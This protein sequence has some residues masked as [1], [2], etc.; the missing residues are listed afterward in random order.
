MLRKLMFLAFI[1]SVQIGIAQKKKA[2]KKAT[3]INQAIYV[4]EVPPLANRTLIQETFRKVEDINPRRTDANKIV[5]GKGY[6]KGQD[7]LLEKQQKRNQILHSGRTPDL[8]FEANSSL[9]AP[10]DPTGAIGPNHYVSAKNSA[11]AIHD[12][13][14]NVMVPSTSL[15]N[16]F[17]GESLGDPI[18]FYDNFADRFVITQFSDSPNGFLVAVC[19]GSDPVN[20]GWY[21]YRFETG[22]FPDY[23]KFSV[24][25]DGYYVTAN[26]DQ[27]SLTEEEVVFVIE[28]E[29]LLSGIADA[30]IVGFPL[31]GATVG[32]FYSPAGFNAIGASLPPEGDARILYFQDDAWETVDEDALKL[33]S[34]NVNW[35]NPSES[36]IE[37]AE[38]LTVSSGA[39]QAFDSTFDGG[40]F[41]NLPQPG[42]DGQDIDV[43]QGAVMYA[44]NYRRFCDYNAVVL[45]FAV[46]IDDRDSSDNISGIRWYELR[47]TSDGAPWT[48]Y[49]EGTYTS[50]NGKS[51]WCA[52]M[53]LDSYGNIGM[54]YTTMGTITNN[55]LEDSFASIRYTGRLTGDPLGVMTI[56]EQ[57]IAIGTGINQ[58]SRN[59][60]GDYA[61][62]TVDP[63]DDQ[64]FWHIAE[65]FE[66]TGN[67]ARNV[68]GAFKIANEIPNDVGVVSID[69]LSNQTYTTT[70]VITVTV[71]NFGTQAQSNI[72]VAYA[73]NG[74]SPVNEVI[75]GPIAAGET[76][77]YSFTTTADLTIGRTLQITAETNLSTDTANINDCSEINIKN[78]LAKDVGVGRLISPSEGN[79]FTGTENVTV[80][81]RNYG[82]EPQSNIPV[83]YTLNN[84]AT[85][86]EIFNETIPVGGA[87]NHTFATTVDLSTLGTY[88]FEVRTTLEGDEDPLNDSKTVVLEHNICTPISDCST[89]G[90]GI[91][92][93]QLSNIT[94]TA[95]VCDN[96]YEDFL[97]LVIDL[98]RGVGSYPLVLQAGFASGE[99]EKFSLWIDFDDDGIFE[100]TEL[101][102]SEEVLSVAEEDIT[103]QLIIPE[104][105]PLGSHRMRIR[106][107]DT[108]ANNGAPLNDPCGSMQYGSTHD[109]T[110]DI[111]ENFS[112]E[113][114][115]VV[116]S[117][118]NDQYT[119]LL[120]DV[121]AP[122]RLRLYVFNILGQ[123]VTS[124]YVEKNA[125]GTFVYQLDM[126]YASTGMY[127]VRLGE[128]K[129]RS[130]KIIVN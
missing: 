24:W 1:L 110:V 40:S 118:V 104:G 54:A 114:G 18:V 21:T 105:A 102:I 30:Q 92:S 51:A 61:Q 74:N 34:I 81:I 109:Y 56:A 59:R 113:D 37:E 3:L 108:N 31:P 28:R 15:E 94:N 127:F 72:P 57:D 25:S 89:F 76:I 119:V 33:W 112:V 35:I 14:G 41:G 5:P 4:K 77:S 60:Y 103:F 66:N 7:P 67:N 124:N 111:Q 11:F 86:Q 93:L 23:T 43:L 12:R 80:S 65:Y 83:S 73:V 98:D 116:L 129:N 100:S 70:E 16:L 82:G 75:P 9:V 10:T 87:A 99:A 52:S 64:T 71:Q 44:S 2:I 125:T 63:R 19:K 45:N 69:N 47:Q 6:P 27:R 130:K 13:L 32:G 78:L 58:T 107:G 88:T 120:N 126:S 53:A 49:Q 85:V 29:K 68:V 121:N 97:N 17:P 42:G 79:S 84:G 39:I 50:P 36:T 22:S 101:L 115:F 26:K 38:E 95:I 48:V 128:D 123:I 91:I 90:D 55:A 122:Q 106:A 46:D 20:D 117:N 8:V 96:G 62:L